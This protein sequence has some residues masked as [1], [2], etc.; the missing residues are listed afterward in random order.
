MAAFLAQ[1]G[2]SFQ[3]TARDMANDRPTLQD[4]RSVRLL[5]QESG[6]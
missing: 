5:E 2:G 3:R 4:L 1:G 6:E